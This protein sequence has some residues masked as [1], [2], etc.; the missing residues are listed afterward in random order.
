M[1]LTI[2]NSK[3][4][5]GNCQNDF[6]IEWILEDMESYDKGDEAMGAETRYYFNSDSTCPNCGNEVK[7]KLELIEYPSDVCELCQI[8]RKNDDSLIKTPDYNF[9]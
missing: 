5:C 3:C 6:D 9:D 2:S 4:T 8:T 7:V 1:A